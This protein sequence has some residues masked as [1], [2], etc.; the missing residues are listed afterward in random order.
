MLSMFEPTTAQKKTPTMEALDSIKTV[1]ALDAWAEERGLLNDDMVQ[2]RRIELAGDDM[3]RPHEC[4]LCD[5]RLTEHRSLLRH[6]KEYN[7]MMRVGEGRIKS[8]CNN[9]FTQVVFPHDVG[10]ETAMVKG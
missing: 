8:L 9:C 2:L 1:N 10:P 3:R 7:H 6:Q 4:P 5:D